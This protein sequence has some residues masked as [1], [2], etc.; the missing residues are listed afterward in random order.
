VDNFIARWEGEARSKGTWS[1]AL[2]DLK[3]R[4]FRLRY[5]KTMRD[6]LL[7]KDDLEARIRVLRQ[8]IPETSDAE[9][10]S[11]HSFFRRKELGVKQGG[12]LR[13]RS[14]QTLLSLSLL[15]NASI[16]CEASDEIICEEE[17]GAFFGNVS[18][19]LVAGSSDDGELRR[20]HSTPNLHSM[21][22][23][24]GFF[25]IRSQ[26]LGCPHFSF[27]PRPLVSSQQDG[28]SEHQQ[29]TSS[30]FTG[31]NFCAMAACF[32]LGFALRS[33][34]SSRSHNAE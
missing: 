29:I 21:P 13:D 9:I 30:F 25:P 12:P 26:F 28:E 18:S 15:R 10:Q 4:D 3:M 23:R 7:K 1:P 6:L 5:E 20:V 19:S 8:Q 27:L 16:Q 33:L 22:Y 11:E 14:M 2:W 31:Q 24:N 34:L 17:G 32:A